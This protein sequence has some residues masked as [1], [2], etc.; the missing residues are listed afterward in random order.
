V[1]VFREDE[2]GRKVRVDQH[3]A[4]DDVVVAFFGY[5]LGRFLKVFVDGVEQQA[6]VVFL[7]WTGL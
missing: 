1:L 3:D 7:L 5:V 6:E 4:V 2:L